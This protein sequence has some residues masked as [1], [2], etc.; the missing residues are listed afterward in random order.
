MKI[1]YVRLLF[2]SAAVIGLTACSDDNEGGSS[3]N[4]SLNT[5]VINDFSSTIA[6]SVYSDLAG[7]TSNLYDEVV[8]LQT[9]GA[10]DE[11]LA[12]CRATWKSARE[13]WEQSEAFLFGPV[14]T[15]NI[16]PRIDT[17]PV[18]FTDLEAQLN[19]EA[20]FTEDYI[21]NLED[22]LKGFHP[23]EYLI[24][25]EEGNKTAA[26]L[27]DRDIE[28]LMGLS[29]NLKELT[30]DL[31]DSWLA[32]NEGSY[33]HAFTKAGD[34]S[35]A[36]PTQLAAFVELVNAMAGI[37]DEVANGKINEV[38]LAQDPTLE[39]S[40]FA[41][42]SITDFTNN[43]KGVQDVYLGKYTADGKGL[44]DIVREYN[45]QLDGDVKLKLSSA[46]TALNNITDP[47]GEAISTQP[48]Q[49]QNAV[50]AIRELKTILEDELLP[51][52]QQHTN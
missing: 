44:E 18:N 30:G 14:S 46:I 16:D 52:V 17:W 27:S 28:Y 40:P 43:I 34:G 36:Y 13:A 24:F 41:Q 22:A 49:V 39:E 5:Q 31:N 51:F 38:F 11:E 32:S 9:G 45:L 42:N 4:E 10:T 23:I 1:K 2:V 26:E 47:F 48:I 15:D 12:A 37:C 21:D 25:G 8:A 50:N 7:K 19:S 29:K 33:H 3:V 6:Q 20:E 35:S